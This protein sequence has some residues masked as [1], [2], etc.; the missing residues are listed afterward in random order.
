MIN[1]QSIWFTFLFSIILV[2]SIFYITM[3]TEKLDEL[4]LDVDTNDTTLVVNESTELVALR[5]QDDEETLDTINELQNILLDQ[6]SDVSAKNDAYDQLLSINNNKSIEINL[7]KIIKKE[8]KFDSFIKIKGNNVT[9]FINNSNHDYKLANDII[10]RLAK[11]FKEDKYI[12][13]KFS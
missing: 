3:D 1:K 7:E 9:V 6:T 12:T 5:V 4:I 8:F 2:L 13:V 11:E 10:N